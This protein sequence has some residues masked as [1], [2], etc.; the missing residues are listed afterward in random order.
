[1]KI[2][3][4]TVFAITALGVSACATD[5]YIGP[6]V[7]VT[8]QYDPNDFQQSELVRAARAQCEAKGYLD[9]GPSIDQPNMNSSG[10]GYKTFSCY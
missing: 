1:M 4:I 5:D 8:V 6:P 9:A 7:T 10:W 2:A 3:A